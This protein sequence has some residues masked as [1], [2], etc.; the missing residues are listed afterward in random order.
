MLQSRAT[1]LI[2]DYL[3]A[4]KLVSGL[5]LSGPLVSNPEDASSDIHLHVVVEASNYDFI[6]KLREKILES[7]YS[8]LYLEEDPKTK[9]LRCVYDNGVIIYLY[10]IIEKEI[11]P[12]S[13]VKIIFDNAN[14]LAKKILVENK[15]QEIAQIMNDFSFVLVKYYNY[16]R[17][18]D[19]LHMLYQASKLAIILKRLLSFLTKD[20]KTIEETE[21]LK[22]IEND[23]KKCQ[24]AIKYLDINQ[25]LMAVKLMM[26]VFDRI[27]NQMT[28]ELAQMVN[29]DLYLFSKERI[30]KL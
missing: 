2:S 29:I 5:F 8:I 7:Y 4:S 28:I 18:D 3:L 22:Y 21:K 23:E 9:I 13:G 24:Q 6:Y 26:S 19:L 11:K 25:S 10:L 20:I 12:L 30:W 15:N 17:G 27:I 14:L 1:K 16:L